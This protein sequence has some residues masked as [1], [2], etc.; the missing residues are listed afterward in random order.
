MRFQAMK[1]QFFRASCRVLC[2]AALLPWLFGCQ[3]LPP[4]H[5]SAARAGIVRAQSQDQ[6]EA[7][8]TMLDQLSPEV[9]ASLPDTR[10]RDLEVWIQETPALYRFATSAYNDA[11]GFWAAEPKRIHLRAGADDLER[12]LAHELVHASLGRSW[13]VLPGTVEEGLCDALSAQLCPLS[14]ARLRAGR[15][16]SAAFALGGLVLELE[17]EVPPEALPSGIALRYSARLRLEGDPPI[18]ID[19]MDVFR[20]QAGLSSTSMPSERKKA[21][22]GLAFV[23]TE[24]IL[25][26]VGVDGLHDLCTRAL[27]AEREEIPADWLLEAADLG[28]D[29]EAWQRAVADALSPA[30]LAELVRMHPQFLAR[31][32][33]DFLRTCIDPQALDSALP[34]VDARLSIAGSTAS[35]S[36]WSVAEVRREVGRTFGDDTREEFARR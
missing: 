11:D 17:I 29:R 35:L 36:L 14:R 10:A 25:A 23:A 3:V 13:R 26:R 4:A 1:T 33:A 28:P 34:W 2:S 6:A 8:A 7:V 21:F 24:R 12:T 16:S 31:T 30:E 9:L 18:E 19:P 32:V 22:Y 15:L 27:S 5:A 20:V